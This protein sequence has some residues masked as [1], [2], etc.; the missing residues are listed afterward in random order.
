MEWLDPEQGGN[1]GVVRVP[2]PVR[3]GTPAVGHGVAVAPDQN[4]VGLGV[5]DVGHTWEVSGGPDCVRHDILV[6]TWPFHEHVHLSFTCTEYQVEV[7]CL[8]AVPVGVVGIELP[9]QQGCLLR[10]GE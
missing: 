5:P 8:L 2:S 6:L 4:E 1:E 3:V 9:C 7:G 10:D